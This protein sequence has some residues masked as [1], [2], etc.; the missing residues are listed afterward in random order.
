MNFHNSQIQLISHKIHHI[1]VNSE[2][3]VRMFKLFMVLKKDFNL[4]ILSIN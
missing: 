3:F 4:Y 1:I 2:G